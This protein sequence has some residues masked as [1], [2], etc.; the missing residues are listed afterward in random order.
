MEFI[1]KLLEQG[2]YVMIALMFLCVFLYERCFSLL[3]QLNKV[4]KT[5]RGFMD[6]SF[7]DFE[8][9]R[10][11]QLHLE[12]L[13]VHRMLTI[14]AAAAS[15]PLL[16]LL[17]TVIGMVSTFESM[18]SSGGKSIEGL[19]GGI[20]MALVT[21]ETGL[22]IAIPSTILIYLAQ[23]QVQKGL[24]DLAEIKSPVAK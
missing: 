11:L 18:S 7:L 10:F 5:N 22:A 21:T 24:K 14:K 8:R 17:G 4:R 9:I 19:A 2:G 15:A 13:I 3:F 1:Q 23:R 12:Q 20:S 6:A 16:G